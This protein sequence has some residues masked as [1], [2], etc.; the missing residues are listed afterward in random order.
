MKINGADFNKLVLILQ[1]VLDVDSEVEFSLRDCPEMYFKFNGGR[2]YKRYENW[3][4]DWVEVTSVTPI[5]KEDMKMY[6]RRLRLALGE[7]FRIKGRKNNYRITENGL[8]VFRLSSHR[9]APSGLLDKL[10]SHKLEIENILLTSDELNTL[11]AT[12][13]MNRDNI[14][15]I[16]KDFTNDGMHSQ[17]L[18]KAK[19]K[20][21]LFTLETFN[22]GEKYMWLDVGTEYE[23]DDLI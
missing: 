15:Y 11:G 5:I 2:L 20:D 10:L 9:W 12:L 14:E 21:D 18:V 23:V 17:I 6:A 19:D 22:P 1:S 3:P 7:E 13:E 8:E 16:K 4:D